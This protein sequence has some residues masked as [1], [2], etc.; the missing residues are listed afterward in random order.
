MT[1]VSTIQQN[2][3]PFYHGSKVEIRG[4]YLRPNRAFN[5]A[6]DKVC[7]GAF[8]TSDLDHA[9]F[10]AINSCLSG[11]GHTKQD[12]KKIYLERLSPNI[13]TQFYIYALNE[14]KDNP[15]I[16]D[17]GTEYYALKPVKIVGE[18][19]F[20]TAEEIRKA[21]YEVYV[22]NEPLKSKANT[23]AGNNFDVQVEMANAIQRGA[24]HR[25]DVD[26]VIRQQQS[27]STFSRILSGIFQKS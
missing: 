11:N 21:G 13:K 6:Q 22:L 26:S 9:K 23:Q 10:F 1:M 8:V 12:G 7:P 15:F 4:G 19:T 24:F 16:H 3:Q 14:A 17:T 18:Q 25:I 20:N 2:K 5:S 27:R